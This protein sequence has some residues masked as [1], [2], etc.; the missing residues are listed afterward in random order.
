MR[1]YDMRRVKQEGGGAVGEVGCA[2]LCWRWNPR[3]SDL[4]LACRARGLR[5]PEGHSES[6]KAAVY[7]SADLT[8][9]L[10]PNPSHGGSFPRKK[11]TKAQQVLTQFNCLKAKVSKTDLSEKKACKSFETRALF[12][13]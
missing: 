10:P 13:H 7:S 2:F 4:L 5:T 6:V 8:R 1:I 3:D 12:N 9:S 11:K